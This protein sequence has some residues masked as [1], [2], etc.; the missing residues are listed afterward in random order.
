MSNCRNHRSD[1]LDLFIVLNSVNLM[2]Q[3][4]MLTSSTYNVQKK[5]VYMCAHI[6]TVRQ[7][8]AQHYSTAKI[9][10]EVTIASN[11]GVIRYI[12]LYF[13]AERLHDCE[14]FNI[15]H[16]LTL[17]D[18]H[19]PPYVRCVTYTVFDGNICKS[20]NKRTNIHHI[21]VGKFCS[22]FSIFP[23]FYCM[24]LRCIQRACVKLYK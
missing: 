23:I 16:T 13:N 20:M 7:G 10:T 2:V 6:V 14:C 19:P 8:A 3:N 18:L 11:F 21:I 24:P 4:H 1:S 22:H 12:E 15:N 5:L 9:I 17:T